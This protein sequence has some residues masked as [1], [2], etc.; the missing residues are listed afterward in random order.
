MSRV[1][2]GGSRGGFF[3][4]GFS[5]SSACFCACAEAEAVI[6]SLKDVTMVRQPIKQSCGH[7]GVAEDTC[8][9]AEA[10]ISGD[11]YAGLFVEL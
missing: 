11:D 5:G 6:A 3:L 9:F 1:A 8:P 7:F 4:S 10:K 2:G